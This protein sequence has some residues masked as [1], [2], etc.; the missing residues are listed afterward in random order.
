VKS[1]KWRRKNLNKTISKDRVAVKSGYYFEIFS[2]DEI[3]ATLEK[4]NKKV[5]LNN[6]IYDLYHGT[7][8]EDEKLIDNMFGDRMGYSIDEHTMSKPKCA[9]IGEDGNIFNL[10]GIA[11]RTLKNNGMRE[12]ATE[13][14]NRIT[15]DAKSYDEALMI[16]D[17][18]VEITSREE[19]EEE[20]F[21]DEEFE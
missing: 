2:R 4:Y 5:E 19:I 20:G 6:V 3:P 13:M 14:C 17:E 12:E 8:L 10:M 18:Y 21:E 7:S 16:I 11:S 15:S 1:K 9:L